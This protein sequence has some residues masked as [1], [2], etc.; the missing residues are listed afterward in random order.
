MA[1]RAPR[2]GLVG[3]DPVRLAVGL[4]AADGLAHARAPGTRGPSTPPTNGRPVGPA[5]VEPDDRRSERP[6]VRVG[7]DDRVA[8]GRHGQRRRSR[9]AGRAGSARTAGRRRRAS[10]SRA[11]GPARPSRAGARRTARSGRA[12]P[13]TRTPAGIEDE[14]AHALRPDV[15]GEDRRPPR[16]GGP[17]SSR[18]P[19][20][21]DP[22]RIERPDD[23]VER[24]PSR[25]R[26]SR[27][28]GTA[29]GR[30]RR[31]AGG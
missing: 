8:L 16:H 9:R 24:R 27:R 26:P 28:P 3:A 2:L 29:R 5:L 12:A 20:V 31:R 18:T 6:P 7:H 15:D 14:R 11:R 1:D 21:H 22:V 23:G 10:A 17:S 4:E 30:A 19:R 25:A 13:A